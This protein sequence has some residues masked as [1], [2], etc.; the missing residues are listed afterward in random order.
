M[1]VRSAERSTEASLASGTP[2]VELVRVEHCRIS[3]ALG[4]G[5]ARPRLSWITTTDAPAWAQAAYEIEVTD[6]LDG[7]P[8]CS[9]RIDSSESVL[10]PW[11]GPALTSRESRSVRVRVW[12]E[13]GEPSQWSEPALLETGLLDAEDWSARFVTPDD[14]ASQPLLRNEFELDGEIARARLYVSALGLYE[15]EINGE[16]VGDHVLAPGWTSYDHRLRYEAFDVTRLLA[17]GPN[18]IGA[19]LGDGWYRG[20]LGWDEKRPDKI[21]GDR[22]GLLAQLEVLYADGTT[23]TIVTDASWR[24]APGPILASNIL[25]GETYDARLERAGWSAPSHDDGDWAPVS[26]LAERELSTVV[27]RMGPPVRRIEPVAPVSVERS[28]SGRTIVDFGQNLAGHLR[29]TVSGPRGTTVTLR[30]GEW[31]A[32]GE[33]Y[34]KNL[35]SAAQTDR[36]TL[37]GGGTETWEPRFTSHGFRY[38]EVNGWPGELDPGALRAVVCHSDMERTGWFECSDERV[39]RLHENVVW[40]MR[41]NFVDVPTDCPQREE[42]LGWTGDICVFGPTASF[43]YDT[44]G[45]LASWLA[46]LAAEQHEDGTISF[47]VPDVFRTGKGNATG[48]WGDVAVVLP[49][50]LYERHGDLGVLRDQYASMKAFVDHVVEQQGPRRIWEAPK[51]FGDWCD[52]GAPVGDEAGG[53]TDRHLLANAWYSR[54]FDLLARAAELLGEA[55]DAAAYRAT[56]AAAR[57][58]FAAEYVTPSGRM[59]SDTQAAYATAIRFGLLP[60]PSQREHAGRRLAELVAAAGDKLTT[61]FVGTPLICDALCDVGEVAA[62][63]RLLLQE[64]RPSWLYPVLLGATTTWEAWDAILRDGKPN[65]TDAVSLNHYSFGAVGDWLHRVVGGLAPAAPGYRQLLIQPTPGHGLTW[66]TSRHRTPYGIAESSWRLDGDEIEV[67]ATVPPNATATVILPGADGEAIEVGSGSHRWRYP[68][69]PVA[70][71]SA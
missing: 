67:T 46:D 56:A 57:E 66:A 27:A 8:V 49:W 34:T 54:S 14:A 32:D 4:L 68:R 26:V 24:S 48:A 55:D 40:S 69:R 45:F 23:R 38:V 43:L 62:A 15:I 70:D 37:A 17:T 33:L 42:R 36:Y 13:H 18:A 1:K 51:Q 60:S 52:P 10:V 53:P 7:T 47:V 29:L 3:D 5:T 44:A 64:E 21:F 30:H 25:D 6:V 71:G 12:G 41:S 28:P 39:N 22:L 9:G 16:R 61:G 65:P 11:P 63:Y 35:G 19:L 20:R 58:A 31:L 2:T 50:T 59:M